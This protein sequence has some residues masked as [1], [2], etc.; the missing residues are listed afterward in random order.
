M[1]KEITLGQAGRKKM[2]SGIFAI[3]AQKQKNL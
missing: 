3:M 2:E 1:M